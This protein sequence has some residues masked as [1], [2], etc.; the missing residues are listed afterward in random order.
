MTTRERRMTNRSIQREAAACSS[1]ERLN[2]KLLELLRQARV[3]VV[4]VRHAEQRREQTPMKLPS[5]CEWTA[6]YRSRQRAAA[7][8]SSASARSSGSLADD[9]PMPTRRDERRPQAAEN[10]QTRQRDVLPERIRDE[11]DRVAELESARMRWYSLNGV[12]RG[13]KN[14]SGAIMRIFTVWTREL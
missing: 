10:P 5:S 13:S 4:E 7:A 2:A 12:P 6:S 3:H 14:G 1:R 8:P 11:I 9:G